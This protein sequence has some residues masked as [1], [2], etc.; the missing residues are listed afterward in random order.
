MPL[1]LIRQKSFSLSPTAI[2]FLSQSNISQRAGRTFAL[3]KSW[4]HLLFSFLRKAE[5]TFTSPVAMLF[6]NSS[7]LATEK[8][9][10][11]LFFR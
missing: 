11:S 9:I 7:S 5:G 8:S 3:Q 4:L 6:E 1:S 2:I 10:P